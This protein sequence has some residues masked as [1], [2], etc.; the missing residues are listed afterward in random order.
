MNNTFLSNLEWRFAT[1]KFDPLKTVS[2]EDEAK[3]LEATRMA[4]T[5]YGLQPFK[6]LIV[7]DQAIRSELKKAS[8]E[9][10]QITDSSLV[11]VFATQNDLI[12]RVNKYIETL[13]GGDE[14]KKKSLLG[15]QKEM[16]GTV[17]SLSDAEA[18]EWA[19]KQAY[20]ALGFALAACA[21]LQI[22]SCPIEGFVAEE[23]DKI[24]GFEEKGL[25]SAVVLAVGYRKEGPAHPKV[26]V[27]KEEL[28]L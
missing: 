16:I 27:S 25:S 18:R 11:M 4:P 23:Y 26:R 20:I 5:S 9:Q 17:E 21:E 13:S 22:D 24:L 10:P 1:K 2:M 15:L 19:G 3:I 7:K 8:Y 12:G 6:V 28:F 14:E